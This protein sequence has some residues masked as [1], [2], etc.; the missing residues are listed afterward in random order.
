MLNY[1]W[2]KFAQNPKKDKSKYCFDAADLF[3]CV[4]DDK[5]VVKNV[6]FF[7]DE[8]VYM[9]YCE[10]DEFVEELANA[11]VIFGGFTTSQ[12][13]L[14]LCSFLEQLGERVLYF[15]SDSVIYTCQPDEEPLPTGRYFGQLTNELDEGDWVFEF[16]S[17]GPKNYAYR[18]RCARFGGLHS[19]LSTHRS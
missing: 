19:I 18:T 6:T 3:K 12:A 1:L 16:V 13:R 15:D 9:V 8:V 17:A 10:K 11:N 14:H 7:N 2:G 4:F 5:N